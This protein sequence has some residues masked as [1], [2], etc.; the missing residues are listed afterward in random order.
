MS[1]CVVM[2]PLGFNSFLYC[3]P[4]CMCMWVDE[5]KLEENACTPVIH[6]L[7]LECQTHSFD[8]EHFLMDRIQATVLF[9]QQ[10]TVYYCNH[11][12]ETIVVQYF[13]SI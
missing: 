5:L 13:H 4:L 6:K 1:G 11:D 9:S 12:F 7:T 2:R 3:A 8:A 10:I